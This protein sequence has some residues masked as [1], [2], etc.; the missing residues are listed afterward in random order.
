MKAFKFFKSIIQKISK[1]YY[2][3]AKYCVQ[4]GNIIRTGIA[5]KL[6]GAALSQTWTY[7]QIGKV[8]LMGK[9]NLSK[10]TAYIICPNHPSSIDPQV[11]HAAMTMS[12]IYPY[13][14]TAAETMKGLNGF[15]GIFM[16]HMGCYP[17][18]RKRGATVVEPAMRLL[19]DGQSTVI[20]PEGN[21][22]PSGKLLPFKHGPATIALG[23]QKLLT[24]AKNTKIK[25][26]AL[27]PVQVCYNFYE[28]DLAKKQISKIGFRWRKGAIVTIG[29]PVY[30]DTVEG[31]S[32]ED[33]MSL[34]RKELQSTPCPTLRG[35]LED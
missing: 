11:I 31:F 19:A 27:L 14:M 35:L 7:A 18:D 26:I 34:V 2:D 17:V 9:E 20:F 13:M 3:H 8:K 10:D 33:V 6:F 28:E 4:S 15:R 12:G 1:P 5:A 29:K 22:S 25:R 24:T 30:M 16:N 21:I 32:T 23:A